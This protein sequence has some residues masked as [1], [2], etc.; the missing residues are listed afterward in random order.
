VIVKKVHFYWGGKKMPLLNA[1]SIVS[2]KKQNPDYKIF[3]Y[4][5]TINFDVATWNS[6]EQKVAYSGDDFSAHVGPFVDKVIF[7]DFEELGFPNDI[8]NAQKAD[9]LRQW[10]LLKKGGWWS[11]MDVI[12][13]KSIS[14]FNL[15]EEYDLGVCWR[16]GYHNSGIM[17]SRPDTNF[18][19]IVFDNLKKH[20]T[21]NSYQ[22]A[23]PSLLNRVFPGIEKIKSTEEGLRVFNFELHNFA[24]LDSNHFP[25]LYQPGN[26]NDVLTND[27]YG[28]H[29][30]NGGTQ[31]GNFVNKFKQ[32]HISNSEILMYK[33]INRA[34]GHEMVYELV[35]GKGA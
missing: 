7:V 4:K 35:R 24:P 18:Y 33:I 1:L 8:H 25:L 9:I 10:L 28:V 2:F 6:H 19:S 20:F 11:D 17:F 5:P 13:A 34:I 31:S 14:S 12:W 30:Y 21:K 29:W 3:L 23:G 16:N 27:V 32:E 26:E 15:E 22:S